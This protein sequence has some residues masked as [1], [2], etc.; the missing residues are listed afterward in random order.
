MY[1]MNINRLNFETPSALAL[2]LTDRVAAELSI[3][4]LE[5]KQAIL[6]VSGGKTP[7]LFFHY[8]SKVDIDWQNVIITLVDERFVPVSDERSNEYCVRRYLLQNFA[9]KARF[10]GLYHKAVTAELAAFSAA[11]RVNT[12]PMPFDV[13]VLGMGIDGHTA[14]F[15]PDG[16]RLEQALDLQSQALVLPIYA[17]SAIEPR[18]TLTL[19]VIIQSRFIALHFEGVQ[20]YACFEEACQNGSEMEMP[21][22]AV[23]QHA[24]HLI[25]VYC[26]P[27]EDEI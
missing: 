10:V 27:A 13:T 4:I 19:P 1:E 12:L 20:K 11:N 8:L 26:S 7:E 5:R 17:R 22:R 9:A 21:I 2:A 16:D 25:Q 18:L 6:A 23:L 14:S 3:S 24:R 15:F